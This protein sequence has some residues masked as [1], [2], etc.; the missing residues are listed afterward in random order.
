MFETVP[1]DVFAAAAE[2]VAAE[3]SAATETLVAAE[4]AVGL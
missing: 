2:S 1:S 4:Y 3:S